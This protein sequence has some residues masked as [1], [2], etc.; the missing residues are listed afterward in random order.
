MDCFSSEDVQRIVALLG[1]VSARWFLARSLQPLKG[2]AASPCYGNHVSNQ[3]K[4]IRRARHFVLNISDFA[5]EPV[6][7]A[8]RHSFAKPLY[9]PLSLRCQ[10]DCDARRSAA[11]SVKS[12]PNN[13]RPARRWFGAQRR[14]AIVFPKATGARNTSAI[15]T[16]NIKS[17][18]CR[19]VG[20]AS[21]LPNT[22]SVLDTG[23]RPEL[24]P[25]R[26]V[27]AFLDPLAFQKPELHRL[28]EARIEN[29]RNDQQ[30]PIESWQWRETKILPDNGIRNRHANGNDD[31]GSH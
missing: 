1:T 17:N 19:L 29:Q 22:M 24:P 6:N 2:R 3:P 25:S 14:P 23:L 8:H 18:P 9:S 20:Y 15:G 27:F 10:G 7:P 5:H 31:C 11:P 16:P 30:R 26:S 4:V 13:C 21:S 28:G 12:A